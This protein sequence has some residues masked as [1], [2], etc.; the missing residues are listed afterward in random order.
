[1]ASY[2][3]KGDQVNSVEDKQPSGEQAPFFPHLQLSRPELDEAYPS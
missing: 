1:M 3:D 2:E